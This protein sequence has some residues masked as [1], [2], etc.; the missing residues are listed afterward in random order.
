MTDTWVESVSDRYIELYEKV[1]GEP[2]IRSESENIL[3]R[4]E[5]NILSVL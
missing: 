5:R 2:F 3:Q 1:T 4:I